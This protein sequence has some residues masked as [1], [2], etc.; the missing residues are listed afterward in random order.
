VGEAAAAGLAAAQAR[1]TDLGNW[2]SCAT[3]MRGRYEHAPPMRSEAAKRSMQLSDADLRWAGIAIFKQAHR[4]FRE[5]RYP[6][7]LMAAY[8]R[9]GPTLEGMPA[10]AWRLEQL[11]G[12]DAVLT[13][14]A[15]IFQGFLSAY[16]DTPFQHRIDEPVPAA[17]LERLLRL[18]NFRS[19]YEEDGLR[20]EQFC[21]HPALVATAAAFTE[22]MVRIESGAWR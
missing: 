20:A 9:L 15:N 18:P 16:R 11:E 3:M 2:R 22:A 1:G 12:A 6:T 13:V 8:M 5:R 17:V 19:A 14:F 7:K 21:S 10:K 4:L